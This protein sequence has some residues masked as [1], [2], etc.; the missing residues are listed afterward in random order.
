M[1]GGLGFE[2]PFG[3]SQLK[4]WR[5]SCHALCRAKRE[6][7]GMEVDVWW[8]CPCCGRGVSPISY[9][10]YRRSPTGSP[11][12]DCELHQGNSGVKLQKRDADHKRL[13]R[14]ERATWEVERAELERR[15][16]QREQEL[17]DRPVQVVRENLD[18]QRVAEAERARDRAYHARDLAN[19]DLCVL[20]LMHRDAGNGLCWCGLL[21]AKC[22]TAR[23]V[24]ENEYFA[25]WERRQVDLYR[26]GQHHYLP[27]NHPAITGRQW[28]S[29]GELID[30]DQIA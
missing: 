7:C 4:V 24:Q 23:I 19:R 5:M 25:A 1:L 11:C 16:A 18:A 13:L 6:G 8:D 29:D 21:A 28:S 20:K 26:R 14:R 17:I 15:I 27:E 30:D 2:Q 22:R 9:G 12:T 3:V 10:G